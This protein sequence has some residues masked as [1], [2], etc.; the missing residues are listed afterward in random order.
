MLVREVK[1]FNL[2]TSQYTVRKLD[3]KLA[4]QYEKEFTSRLNQIKENFDKLQAD[5]KEAHKEFTTYE[6]W[7]DYLSLKQGC[8]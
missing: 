6:F 7:E 3:R 1:V 4:I 2:F 8:S 5:Y